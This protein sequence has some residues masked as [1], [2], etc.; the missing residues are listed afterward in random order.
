MGMVKR[1]KVKRESSVLIS[2]LFSKDSKKV[3]FAK[4]Y[5]LWVCKGFRDT[6]NRRLLSMKS[7]KAG[8]LL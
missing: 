3:A 7:F 4:R 1:I 5:Q 6:W 2:E 8:D